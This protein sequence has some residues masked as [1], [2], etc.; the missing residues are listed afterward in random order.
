MASNLAG[1]GHAKHDPCSACARMV[2]TLG[3]GDSLIR[4]DKEIPQLG[5]DLDSEVGH[6]FRLTLKLKN[7]VCHWTKRRA[8]RACCLR[9]RGS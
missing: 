3:V 1:T 9:S 5:L 7:P 4:F 2:S 8:N 6:R